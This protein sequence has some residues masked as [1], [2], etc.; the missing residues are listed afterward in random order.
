MRKAIYE[1]QIW[2]VYSEGPCE[3]TPFKNVEVKGE[4]AYP[5]TAKV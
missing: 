2:Q 1:L 3:Q 4:W 5:G